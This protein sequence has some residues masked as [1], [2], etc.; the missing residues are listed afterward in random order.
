MKT[1]KF[2][3][4]TKNGKYKVKKDIIIELLRK[5]QIEKTI[6]SGHLSTTRRD[7]EEEMQEIAKNNNDFRYKY[8]EWD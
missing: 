7:V 8:N 3:K 5:R 2:V 6:E 4:K 1:T